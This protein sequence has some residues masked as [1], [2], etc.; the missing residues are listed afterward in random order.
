MIILHP[1]SRFQDRLFHG[2]HSTCFAHHSVFP[3]RAFEWV[4]RRT[5]PA[6][7]TSGINKIVLFFNY[8]STFSTKEEPL[9]GNDSCKQVKGPGLSIVIN[10]S[11][12]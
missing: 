6:V 7:Y 1:P 5:G 2:Y 8:L 9:L 4:S 3:W 11:S 12:S 10:Y